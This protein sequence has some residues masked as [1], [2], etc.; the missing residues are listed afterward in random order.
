MSN[1]DVETLQ[2]ENEKLRKTL[3]SSEKSFAEHKEKAKKI[4][5][6]QKVKM[7]SLLKELEEYKGKRSRSPV[8][9]ERQ[10]NEALRSLLD[11]KSEQIHELQAA[12]DSDAKTG[13][14]EK[15]REA[16][17]E[18]KGNRVDKVCML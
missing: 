16:Q 8:I 9:E 18:I 17:E 11:Q 2:A 15:L 10:E 14:N 6:T 5:K 7:Q 1:S 12:L 3:E 4:V 13:M